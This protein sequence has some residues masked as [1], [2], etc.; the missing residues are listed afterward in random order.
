MSRTT[1]YMFFKRFKQIYSR[2]K[3][4]N[5]NQPPH[6]CSSSCSWQ[7]GKQSEINFISLFIKTFNFA[8]SSICNPKAALV[9]ML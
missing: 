6:S 7:W 1:Q 5:A 3:L 2:E 8:D 9:Q 4:E